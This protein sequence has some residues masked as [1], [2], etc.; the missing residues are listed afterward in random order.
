MSEPEESCGVLLKLGAD[1]RNLALVAAAER[2]SRPRSAVGMP[3]Q[4]A[5]GDHTRPGS[6]A[7]AVA[8]PCRR[9]GTAA[10][11]PDPQMLRDGN[12]GRRPDS[13]VLHR[14]RALSRMGLSHPQASPESKKLKQKANLKKA[15]T[16][17]IW[18]RPGFVGALESPTLR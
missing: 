2:A 10:H 8:Q 14:R 12:F 6:S 16:S 13:P 5:L 11:T 15:Y 9:S 17:L 4:V 18:V 3:L 1:H 7:A